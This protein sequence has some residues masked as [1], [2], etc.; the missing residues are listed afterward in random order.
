MGK[1]LTLTAEKRLLPTSILRSPTP[2]LIAIMTFA[3]VV[4]AAAGL[5]VT[6]IA[7]SV[8]DASQGRSVAQIADGSPERT[9]EVVESLSSVEG[10]SGVRPVGRDEIRETLEQWLGPAGIGDLPVPALVHFEMGKQA[11][12]AAVRTAIENSVPGVRIVPEGHALEPLLD[13]LRRLQ[14]LALGLVLL[15]GIASAGA[16]VLATRGALDT[17]RSTIAIL[18]GIGATDE[19]IAGLF[20]RLVGLAAAAGAL[21]G[22]TAAAI[23]LILLAGGSG[24]AAGLGGGA[25][26]LPATDLAILFAIPLIAVGLATL[27]ARLAVL[28]A[29]RS[30]I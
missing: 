7:A 10:V 17:H 11:D 24:F 9:A 22:A 3:M 25:D 2:W 20:Q 27:V 23:V 15:L 5:V 28:G 18:H 30:A 1:G 8:A 16:I 6:A 29:L 12:P 4:V 26:I 19:Q 13:S 21:I 14:F